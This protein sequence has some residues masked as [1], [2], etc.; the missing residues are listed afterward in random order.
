MSFQSNKDFFVT[1]HDFLNN[2]VWLVFTNSKVTTELQNRHLL[3]LRNLRIKAVEEEEEVL[4]V[5]WLYNKTIYL[6]NNPKESPNSN[7]IDKF[8]VQ[9]DAIW[10]N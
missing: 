9:G 7:P 2:L 3:F 6:L 10:T 8:Q 1:K 4:K 5:I